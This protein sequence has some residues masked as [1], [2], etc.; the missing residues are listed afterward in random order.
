VIIEPGATVYPDCYL[1]GDVTIRRGAVLWPGVFAN[2]LEGPIEIG[3]GAKVGP[4]THLRKGTYL[5]KDTKAGSFVETKNLKLGAG[6][7]LPHLSYA[8]D[9]TIG[10]R[11]NI[12]CG[13][14]FAN[15]DGVNKHE[16]TVGDDVRLGSDTVLVAPVHVGDRVYTGAGTIVRRD[17]PADALAVNDMQM[18]LI[19]DWVK[20]HR[21]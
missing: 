2:G 13:T 7:K 1:Y 3:E 21:S 20:L 8:G 15:Y 16:S 19:T 6:S 11:T 12:G 18:R 14:I 4:F 5:G 17:I 10:E 9:A